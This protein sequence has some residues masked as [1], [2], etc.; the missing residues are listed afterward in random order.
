MSEFSQTVVTIGVMVIA[1]LLY[2]I[3]S[4]LETIEQLLQSDDD[5]DDE[6]Y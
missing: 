1:S 5:D 2:R 4:Q 3:T 6:D